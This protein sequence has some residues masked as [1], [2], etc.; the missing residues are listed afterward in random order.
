M[1]VDYIPKVKIVTV[2][3]HEYGYM[4]WLKESCLRNNSELTILGEG[5]EW[6]GYSMRYEL[7]KTFLEGQDDRDVICFIDAYDVI[8]HKDMSGFYS[9]FKETC[10]KTNCKIICGYFDENFFEGLLSPLNIISK[11]WGEVAFNSSSSSHINGG[12]YAGFVK[13]LKEMLELLVDFKLKNNEP[14]DEYIINTL[15]SE[16]KL[17]IYIDVKSNFFKNINPRDLVDRSDYNCN[18]YFLHR[19]GGLP[20]FSYLENN[21]YTVTNEEKAKIISDNINAGVEKFTYHTSNF[22]KRLMNKS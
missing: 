2:A 8:V 11:T 6:K 19:I 14:D 15:Y 4:K 13:E 10:D 9:E 12:T 5:L 18:A 3:T 22:L 21:S 7:M 16:G 20:L 17:Q 1:S